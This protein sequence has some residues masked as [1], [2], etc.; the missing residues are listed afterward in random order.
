MD[1]PAVLAGEARNLRRCLG[2]S[3]NDRLAVLGER[4]GVDRHQHLGAVAED[5]GDCSKFADVLGVVD[6][7]R[8][9]RVAQTVGCE[10][11]HAGLLHEPR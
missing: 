7:V 6:H 4:V 9:S 2:E 1:S 3:V 5:V 11:R 8:G 10:P